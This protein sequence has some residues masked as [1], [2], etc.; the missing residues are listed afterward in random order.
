[1]AEFLV[2]HQ[3]VTAAAASSKSFAYVHSGTKCFQTRDDAGKFQTLYPGL[4]NWNTADVVATSVD[5]YLTGSGIVVPAGQQI[6]VG[7][8]Y[9]C[10][11]GMTK[12]AA[13]TAAPTWTFRVG[14]AGT[15]GDAGR[16]S[17]AGVVQTA[18]VDTGYVDIVVIFRTVGASG[19]C[20]GNLVMGHHLAATGFAGQATNVLAATSSTFDTTPAG[21]ILGISVNPNTSAV[22]THQ[23]IHAELLNI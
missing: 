10:R 12:T 9:K 15:T 16:L 22:W 20:T 6:Q 8:T 11:I 17:L 21:T 19:V 13:G 23:V 2:D 7:T 4:Q 14:T 5:T 3:V 18:A 1:M